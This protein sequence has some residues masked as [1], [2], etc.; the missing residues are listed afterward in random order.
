MLFDLN[1]TFKFSIKYLLVYKLGNFKNTFEI[2]NFKKMWLFFNLKKL[3]DM[4]DIQLYNNFY[5]IKFFFG[6]TAF[7]SK[8]KKIFL[9]GT[10]YYNT[11]AQIIIN[12]INCIHSILFT[13]FNNIIVNIEKNLIKLSLQNKK[14]I[15]FFFILINDF[16][17]YSELKT[18]MALFNI[19]KPLNIKIY[20][21]G[22][23]YKNNYFFIKTLKYF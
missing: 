19:K 2:P 1:F 21:N 23:N 15:N 7:F 4:D 9:L 17:I 13:I 6:K 3:E 18:N 12:N 5:L 16:N 14:K 8:T 11:T 22:C 20:F 10:W